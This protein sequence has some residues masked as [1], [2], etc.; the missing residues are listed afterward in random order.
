MTE[1]L[2]V[3]KAMTQEL[4]TMMGKKTGLYILDPPTGSS[5]SHSMYQAIAQYLA[6]TNLQGRPII[7]LTPQKKNL[8]DKKQ[9]DMYISLFPD[10][11]KEA[12][13]RFDAAFLWL[14]NKDTYMER[15]VKDKRGN[16]LDEIP[17]E[18]KELPEFKELEEVLTQ[19]QKMRNLKVLTPSM[20][21]SQE[22]MY[23][24]EIS[25]AEV[26]FRKTLKEFLGEK[27]G[28]KLNGNLSDDDTDDSDAP[29]LK[30]SICTLQEKAA[31]I[32]KLYPGT[33]LLNKKLIFMSFDKF[34]YGNV[35]LVPALHDFWAVFD[36]QNPILAIDELDSTHDVCE[37]FILKQSLSR[38][39]DLIQVFDALR[40]RLENPQ[41][42]PKHIFPASFQ[43]V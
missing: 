4:Y 27:L 37:Q 40:R 42:L 2:D 39:D 24:D 25:R 43:L 28:I 10:N 35:S 30:Q 36:G 23:Q 20:I 1:Q 31:W 18:V 5:K 6:D 11:P 26:N 12:G 3:T 32:E 9:K 38:T 21:E 17:Q 15:L 41:N 13:R 22:K 34:C 16:I 8:N 33:F 14:D 29:T 7:F 19:R